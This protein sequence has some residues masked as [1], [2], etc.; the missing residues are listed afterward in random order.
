MSK[1]MLLM[2]LAGLHAALTSIPCLLA[3]DVFIPIFIADDAASACFNTSS[4]APCLFMF[5]FVMLLI[6]AFAVMYTA[7]GIIPGQRAVMLVAVVE[8]PIIAAFMF[9]AYTQGILTPL[10]LVAGPLCDLSLAAGVAWTLV[11]TPAS[12]S[13]KR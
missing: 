5:R 4:R 8:K 10:A 12:S 1:R 6:S 2:R 11:A 9:W 7:A 3:H 13:G